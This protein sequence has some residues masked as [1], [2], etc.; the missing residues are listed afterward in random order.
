MYIETHSGKHLSY[1]IH[2]YNGLK[3]LHRHAFQLRFRL[4]IQEG[5]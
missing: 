5:T 1:E 4:C 3:M 2:I